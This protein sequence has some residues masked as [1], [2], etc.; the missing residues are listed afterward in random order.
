MALS[1][2]HKAA[3]RG[4]GEGMYL[5][6]VAYSR[7][8]GVEKDML[9]AMKWY[10]QAA[11]SEKYRRH[12]ALGYAYQYGMKCSKRIMPRRWNGSKMLRL[13]RRDRDAGGWWVYASGQGVPQDYSE[14]IKWFMKAA[15]EGDGRGMA[16]VAH[17]YEDWR[18][19][20][21]GT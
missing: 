21:G 1:W 9:E 6:G 17:G 12:A 8:D 11:A 19:R 4:D 15:D 13:G 10:E 16:S 5:I 7:G 2:Y 18:G 14:A 3:D 20:D